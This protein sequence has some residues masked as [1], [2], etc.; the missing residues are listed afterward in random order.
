[1][2]T[3]ELEG[4]VERLFKNND[5]SEIRDLRIILAEMLDKIKKLENITSHH[6]GEVNTLKGETHDHAVGS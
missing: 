2:T 6:Y 1:M 4:M 5:S 3:I